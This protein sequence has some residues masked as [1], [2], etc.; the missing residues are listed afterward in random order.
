MDRWRRNKA[1]KG[2]DV[3]WRREVEIEGDERK[4]RKKVQKW[5]RRS[6]ARRIFLPSSCTCNCVG[7]NGRNFF[8]S[9]TCS[10]ESALKK[11]KKRKKKKR[12]KKKRR[13]RERIFYFIYLF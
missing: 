1:D 3:M 4:L 9:L 6:G 13:R 12:K 8:L 2:R 10:L 7:A 5:K 11:E